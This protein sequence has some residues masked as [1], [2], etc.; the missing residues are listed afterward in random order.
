MVDP[1]KPILFKYPH[2][3]KEKISLPFLHQTLPSIVSH[4]PSL[5]SP[6][7][8]TINLLL[9]VYIFHHFY[10]RD[11]IGDHYGALIFLIEH[12]SSLKSLG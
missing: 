8:Q 5:P 11:W 2:F 7:S 10:N 1:V 12:P 3:S 6:N 4:F 9:L